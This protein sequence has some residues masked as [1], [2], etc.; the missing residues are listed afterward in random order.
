MDAATTT[1]WIRDSPYS[2]PNQSIYDTLDLAKRLAKKSIMMEEK[3]KLDSTNPSD[4]QAIMPDDD[5]AVIAID[6]GSDC[7][8]ICGD[9][10]EIY[11]T[12]S[13]WIEGKGAIKGASHDTNEEKA[14]ERKKNSRIRSAKRAGKTVRRLVNT[15]RLTYMWTLTFAPPSITNNKSYDT[16]PL[17]EQRDA[18]RVKYLFTRFRLKLEKIYPNFKWL[19]VYELHDSEKTSD[20]KRGTW[21]LHFATER[22]LDWHLVSQK[23]KHGVVRFDNFQKAKKGVRDGAVRNPGAYM[24]KYIGKNF[25]DTNMHEKRYSR[26]RNMQKPVKTTLSE[27]LCQHPTLKN[28]TKVFH[29]FREFECDGV[30]YYNQNITFKVTRV[31]EEDESPP[32]PEGG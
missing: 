1:A 22:F 24:S 17:E 14:K 21:H 18:K 26:S 16:I 31:G 32:L 13:H 6:R 3:A 30:R 25:S 10:V 7:V 12:T 27:Y 9:F 15:N 11:I 8:R 19:V 5:I 2:V 20:E 4:N 29:T 23:W 28:H